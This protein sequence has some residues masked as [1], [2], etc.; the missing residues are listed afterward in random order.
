M[1]GKLFGIC[2]REKIENAKVDITIN[3]RVCLPKIFRYKLVE[4]SQS[5]FG[6]R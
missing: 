1:T 6:S 4:V 2:L 3:F 5:P